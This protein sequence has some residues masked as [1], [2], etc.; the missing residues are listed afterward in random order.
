MFLVKTYTCEWQ[1][2]GIPNPIKNLVNPWTLVS[3]KMQS[4]W[5]FFLLQLTRDFSWKFALYFVFWFTV[6][7]SVIQL[8]KIR[9]RLSYRLYLH[10]SFVTLGTRYLS[11][12]L[13]LLFWIWFNIRRVFE[14]FSV[15]SDI[16]GYVSVQIM[17]C[18]MNFTSPRKF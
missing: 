3:C 14:N 1:H 2:S 17:K 15:V 9:V 4:F 11:F 5:F 7:G 13:S 10:H 16:L 6:G 8:I 18:T 12:D